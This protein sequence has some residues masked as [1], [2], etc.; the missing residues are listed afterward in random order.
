MKLIRLS[1]IDAS[2]ID[3]VGGKAAGLGEMIKVGERVPDGFCLTVEAYSSRD[4]PEN[5]VIGAYERLGGGPVAVR[6]S[7][8]AEDLPDASFAGQQD[9]FLGVNG[10]A[11]LVDAIHKCWDSLH[12]DRAVAY[13]ASAGIDD[14]AM[15]VVIQRMIDPVVAG[16]L[17][18]A[19]PITG[20]RTEM[21][22]DAAPGL[23]TAVVDGTVV[24][25]H[26]VLGHARTV[27]Q[28]PEGCLGTQEL[29]QLRDAG[30]RLQRH[31]GSPQ[32]IEWAIDSDGVLWLLQ[33]RPITTLFPLPPDTGETRLYLEFGHIQG[34]LRP[35][36]P[37]GISLLKAGSAQWFHAH[38]VHGDP[39]DPLP[40]MVP[41]G[42]RLYFDL[43]AFVR[44]K[45]MRKRLSTSLQVYGPRVQGAVEHM[46]TDPRFAPR[47]GLPFRL[48]NLLRATALLA[49]SMVAGIASSVA[50]PDAARVRSY[51]AVEEIRRLT[52]PPSNSVTT[53]ERLRWV[54]E[55]S[56]R[57]IM[58]RGMLG[59]M[60]PLMAGILLGAAP[61]GL[62][63]GIASNEE[64]DIVVGGMPHNVTTEMDLLLWNL[65]VNAR[66]H[67]EIFLGITPDEL[68]ARYR[69]G[70]LPDIG[71][72]EF[73]E[74]YGMRAAA[75]IDVGMPR[76]DEDPAPLFATIANY[77]RVDDPELAPD[78]RFRQ[79]A[80]KAEAMIETLSHRARRRRP[81]RGRIATFLMRRS[82]KLT[83]LREIGK[84]AWLPAIQASRRQLLLV[85]DDLVSR[86]L[87]E[88]RD[89]I[90]FLTLDEARA[91][92]HDAT[93]HRRLVASRRADHRR[94][95]RRSTVPG[96]LL[97]DGT[98]VEALVP[99]GPVQDGVL[100]GM[101]GAAGQATG[102]ARV[103]RDPAGAYIE[104][105]EI[106][107][108]PTTDPGWTPLFLTTAGLVT[109]TGSPVAHGPTVAR[110]YGIPAV[111]CV[112]DATH[113][114]T[115]GQ[116]I[117]IDGT[118]GTVRVVDED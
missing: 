35:C 87:L 105:G 8:T 106:L 45:A 70:Q 80:H 114:I 76:W 111:I 41:I 29:E 34:M 115:T 31:F 52:V 40:R 44:H 98:D 109:E 13:R 96:A 69:T 67:R 79:A 53:A 12:S 4:L 77:L 32:D 113:E 48:G 97:S 25:D 81:V 63:K 61:S 9:T 56:H 21:I 91:A 33:S 112:R 28:L 74:R 24:P 95:L 2:M 20:C 37:M 51:R 116:L 19:N 17:F 99:P 26:Y 5:E 39:R 10:P 36:T 103:I 73:L 66:K 68:A 65:A 15:A 83:G 3:L 89:D 23:G 88:S 93:D 38:G 60:G 71:M 11:S 118:A 18:T 16:V 7:A 90:M 22:V 42:G 64:L 94:E 50:R 27:P 100:T 75:E 85:G 102:R 107:V 101:A 110:E 59:L 117:T 84:F 43:T 72:A 30:L 47:R 57:A 92:V 54:I 86:G 46:M 58:S 108:A 104:P 55:D 78:R 1:E 62:L 14:A 82:R 6:S 49:P